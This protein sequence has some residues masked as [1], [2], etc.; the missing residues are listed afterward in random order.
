MP[1]CAERYLTFLAL[2]TIIELQKISQHTDPEPD[3]NDKGCSSY[4]AIILPTCISALVVR[5]TSC[6]FCFPTCRLHVLACF[7]FTIFDL[8]TFL[9]HFIE[10][11]I[12]LEQFWL[13]DLELPW[14]RC[15]SMDIQKEGNWEREKGEEKNKSTWWTQTCAWLISSS[16]WTQL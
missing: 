12:R 9:H 4:T 3:V 11:K 10:F 15:S 6:A 8:F 2:E 7:V 1:W 14:D 13:N 5:S 16:V